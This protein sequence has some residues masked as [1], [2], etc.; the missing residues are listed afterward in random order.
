VFA[1]ING[2]KLYY[3]IAGQGEP[4][5]TLHGGPGIGD[6]G[7]NKKMF[8]T[9]E[10]KFQFIYYDQ[11]GNGQSEQCDP[12]TYTHDQYVLDAEG[13]RSH[14]G[15][16]RVAVSGGS[17]GGIIALEYALQ[18]PSSIKC[19]VLR[20]T[21]ASYALQQRAFENALERK[22][23][24]VTEELLESLFFGQMKDNDDLKD[25]FSKICPL[26]SLSY[27]P[28]KVKELIDRKLFFAETHNAFFTREFPRY[29]IRH[30]LGEIQPPTLIMAGRYDW[31]TPIEFAE[32]LAAGIPH[33]KLALFENAGH[34]IHSDEPEKFYQIVTD[35][36]T[37]KSDV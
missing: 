20:G 14:L 25:K 12:A 9:L 19:M 17:Y 35:F 30:R 4:V 28:D 11:R 26:Y 33:S 24:E 32:E 37:T 13:L 6:L 36:L 34:S 27:N 5:L 16:D 18:F 2:A 3:E 23:P 31:I 8:A 7:D 1:T 10:D 21:A 22:L 29:D 15:L